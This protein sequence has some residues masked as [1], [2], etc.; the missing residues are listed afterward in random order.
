MAWKSLCAMCRSQYPAH[1]TD[2]ECSIVR[3]SSLVYE[4]QKAELPRR[5][6]YSQICK[7]LHEDIEIPFAQASMLTEL[8]FRFNDMLPLYDW[9]FDKLFEAEWR[10]QEG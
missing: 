8:G 10:K 6:A 7:F 9:D 4:T 5:L 3:V 2:L 1:F